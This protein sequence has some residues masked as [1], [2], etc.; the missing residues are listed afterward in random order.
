MKKTL[1]FICAIECV[2]FCTTTVLL[3]Q[4]TK[5]N[6]GVFVKEL[7]STK[8]NTP[9]GI[10]YVT[11]PGVNLG[12]T[13]FEMLD[14]NRI[15]YLCN[16]TNEII[17]TKTASGVATKKFSVSSAPRDFIYDKGFFYVLFERQVTVYNESGK[18]SN[19]FSFPDSYIGVERIARYNNETYLLLPSGNCA[20]IESSGKIITPQEFEGWIISTGDFISTKLTN[21]SLR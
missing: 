6:T 13:S 5:S 4:N 9:E 21:F 16:A 3:A 20:K 2:F 14:E 11:A 15:A 10:P 7:S 19:S 1:S 8:W 12:I 17:I 18:T